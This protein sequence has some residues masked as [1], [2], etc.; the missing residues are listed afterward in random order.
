MSALSAILRVH[1][2]V[3]KAS[4]G[5]IGHRVLG[6]PTLLL[7]TTGRRSGEVRTSSLVYARDGGDYLLV[8]SKGGADEPPAWLLNLEAESVVEIQIGRERRK[9][10]SRVV[11]PSRPRLRAALEDRQRRELRPLQRLPGRNLAA[12]PGRRRH[13]GLSGDG[14]GGTAAPQE[15]AARRSGGV[16]HSP[17]HPT[18]PDLEANPRRPEGGATLAIGRGGDAG[19]T[20]L[21]VTLAASEDRLPGSGLGDR[22]SQGGRLAG[23]VA[24]HLGV[25]LDLGGGVRADEPGAVE[26]FCAGTVSDQRATAR[27]GW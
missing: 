20:H 18:L 2:R 8:A 6:V 19:L 13:P 21:S 10:R 7:R 4:G 25:Q 16:A 26:G 5:R 9:G 14:G 1:D 15:G 12:D 17:A 22:G 24:N 11:T 3:Y 23:I 27:Q